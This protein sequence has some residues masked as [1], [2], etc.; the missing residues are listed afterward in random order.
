[1]T[2]D[3]ARR[4]FLDHHGV[5]PPLPDP[6]PADASA[7]RYFRLPDTPFGPVLL[8]DNGG[9]APDF[10]SYLSIAAH[11]RAMGLSAPR[12][13]AAD[14]GRGL[15]LIEDFGDATYTRL[16]AR[17]ADEAALYELAIDA[18]AA[19]H[20][21]PRAAEIRLPAYDMAPLLR[22]V[23]LFPDWFAPQVGDV[24]PGFR[25]RFA[26]LWREALCDVAG[27]RETL[28]LRDYHV[29][30]LL[31]LDGRGGVAA[32]GLLDFQDGLIGAAAYDVMSLTQ[33]ARRDLAPGLEAQLLHRYTAARPDLD[34]ARFMADY[35]L[36][37][38]QRHTKVAGIFLR[39]HLRDSKPV[40]LGHMPRVL[41]LLDEALSAASL[42]DL[43]ALIHDALPGWTGWTADRP[44]SHPS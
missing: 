43:R 25:A 41:R 32:C 10:D 30:N 17:G 22:E 9:P 19:L 2:T 40:Y 33:D 13:H 31:R 8:M 28:V 24:P 34:S 26:A 39:L 6:L 42:T 27:R 7:R 15:A 16:L 12:V 4:A 36:L 11:L 18:L 44:V 20:E 23:M 29:D 3:T 38:A 5:S 14:T 35:H 1:M 21:D 37:G